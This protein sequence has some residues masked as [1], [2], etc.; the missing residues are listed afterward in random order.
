MKYSNKPGMHNSIKVIS[1]SIYYT[2][3]VRILEKTNYKY[4]NYLTQGILDNKVY[5][6]YHRNLGIQDH[7]IILDN[8]AQ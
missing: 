2:R 6:E 1:S 3:D 5:L 8:K 4:R 7:R